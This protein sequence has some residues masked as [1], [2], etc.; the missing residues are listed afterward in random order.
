MKVPLNAFL[1]HGK[2]PVRDLMIPAVDDGHPGLYHVAVEEAMLLAACREQ[3]P[4]PASQLYHL[5]SHRRPLRLPP[6]Q[7]DIGSPSSR[8][9]FM[10]CSV[11]RRGKRK[12]THFFS[13]LEIMAAIPLLGSYNMGKFDLSHSILVFYCDR[14][15]LAPLT[16]SRSY[17]NVPQPH[18]AVYY[19]QRATDGG[20]LITEATGVSHTAQG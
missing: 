20:L 18:A 12:N 17:G 16:R 15:V 5:R 14:I 11:R 10:N 2:K 9:T 13:A 8:R 4:T 1:P 19:S 6:T 3:V 7:C